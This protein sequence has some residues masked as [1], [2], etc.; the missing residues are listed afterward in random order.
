VNSIREL[1]E[2]LTTIN[3]PVLTE[4]KGHLDH[5]EDAIFIGGSS[6]AQTA[7][8]AIVSTV[9]NPNVVTIK[10]DGYPAII[11]GRGPNGKFA[12]MDKH[13]F[14]KGD[15]A[16]RIAYTPELFRKYDLGRGVD[17][18]G[19][20]EILNQVWV[21]LSKEDQS[22]GYY[23]GD[24]LFS[25]PL[26]EKSGLY[27]FK[28]NPN[29]ITYTVD[30]N[31]EVGKL[32]A[33]KIAGIAVHQ[34]I[35]PSAASTDE[36]SSLNGSI[37]Q[38]K[39]N[40]N[41]AIIPSKMPIQAKLKYNEQQKSKADQLISQYGQ[42]VDQLL[43][44]PAGCKSFLNSNLFTSFINQKVRQGNFNNLLKDFLAFAQGKQLTD[45]VRN[46]IFGYV[47]PTTKKKVPGHFEINKQGLIGAFMIWSAIYNLKG[48]VVK[49]LDKASK[50]S[51]V[52]GYLQDGTQTQ[53]GY[54]AYG[55]KF[56]DRMGFSRQ[57][58]LGR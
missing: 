23:W 17:R 13:M 31:S 46:K 37:G 38:L 16:G 48:P 26:Q 5:P 47:D 57:N 40:S 58:L 42:A 36:A 54:V 7:V 14:N 49:Q 50:N 8:N 41:V 24:L 9:Q 52:K 35:K 43:V 55:F 1:I 22:Q 28:A 30:V 3:A 10:W 27:T 29:G 19:L 11:F 4:A 2:T 32:M 33:G 25:Q 6:Y 34:F 18:S 12:I 51:P 44:A 15:G 21:G 45:P 53:E 39:N 56:V 20:H